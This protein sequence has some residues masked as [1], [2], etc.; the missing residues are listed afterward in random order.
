MA[1][2]DTKKIFDQTNDG[3][4]IIQWLYE[5]ADCNNLNKKFK[6]RGNE[7]TASAKLSLYD[8]IYWVTD[9][10]GFKT[11]P[12]GNGLKDW[13]DYMF[14]HTTLLEKDDPYLEIFQQLEQFGLLHLRV[15]DKMGAESFA[16]FVFDK[17]NEVL[18]KT[19]ASR[20]QVIKVECFENQK[21][22]AIYQK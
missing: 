22:S 7:K 13:M 12:K 2:Y 20:C 4:Q 1:F 14:D 18:S 11:A 21:N 15:M 16:K 8:G 17:F 3:L 19:D 9:F 6:A 10:G 5:D